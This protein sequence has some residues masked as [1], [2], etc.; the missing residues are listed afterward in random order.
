MKEDYWSDGRLA[1]EGMN[2]MV[3]G[4]Q[5]TGQVKGAVDWDKI[6]DTNLT[7]AFRTTRAVLPGMIG[8]GWGR[9]VNIV[10]TAA[11]VG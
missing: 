8:R 1:Y 2:R 5:I 9:I 6:V 4:L 7:G 10:S 3:E 11:S